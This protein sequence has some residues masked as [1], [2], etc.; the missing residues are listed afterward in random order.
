[1]DGFIALPGGSGE[2]LDLLLSELVPALAE[3]RRFRHAYAGETLAAHLGL[4]S[5]AS[6][7]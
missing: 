1:M 4:A 3:A 2:S 7:G 5:P 6:S